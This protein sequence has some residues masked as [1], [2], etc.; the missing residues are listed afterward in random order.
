MGNVDR[1]G[2]K[3]RVL[4]EVGIVGNNEIDIDWLY[5]FII[6]LYTNSG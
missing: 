2:K 1:M 4:I 5:N 6:D 3:N